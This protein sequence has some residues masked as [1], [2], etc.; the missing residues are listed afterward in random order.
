MARTIVI[1]GASDGIGAA[2]ARQL[3]A[4]GE[5]VVVV[6]HSPEKTAAVARALNAPHHVADYADL[7]QVRR[8]AAELLTAYPRIDVLANN[9]GGIFKT[10]LTGDG[11]DRM[12]QVNHLAPFLLTHLLLGRLTE[13]RAAV[14]QTSSIG[15][16]MMG[17]LDIDTFD[18]RTSRNFFMTYGDTKL[19]N[20]LFTAELHRRHHAQGLN[21]VSFHPGNIASSFPNRSYTFIR[22]LM[23]SPVKYLLETSED[24]GARLAWLAEGRPGTTW[25]PGKYY[26]N[27]EIPPDRKINAQAKDAALAAELWTK[28]ERLLGLASAH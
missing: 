25:Q 28:S 8:L 15:A 23:N 12:I 7:A 9:A 18:G 2:A 11:F 3:A 19:M 16:K 14:I 20:Q 24:G 22:L 10:E 27:N 21:A 6:G 26:E 4:K 13:S 1:T 17:K 5:R